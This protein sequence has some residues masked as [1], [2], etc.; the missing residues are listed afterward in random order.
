MSGNFLII[1]RFMLWSV[2]WHCVGDYQYYERTSV[3]S[4]RYVGKCA[5]HCIISKMFI[6]TS[7][8]IFFCN[9][10]LVFLFLLIKLFCLV[11][12]R[13]MIHVVE[14]IKGPIKWTNQFTNLK[15]IV[16]RNVT[17]C[18][19]VIFM[20]IAVRLYSTKFFFNDFFSL[21]SQWNCNFIAS[22]TGCNAYQWISTNF[23]CWNEVCRCKLSKFFV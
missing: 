4:Y 2:L 23:I 7:S 16:I 5:G 9:L 1:L 10:Y 20:P 14:M 11:S 12:P 18:S 6:L 8:V 22:L 19:L 21:H 3:S 15:I 17:P 13:L